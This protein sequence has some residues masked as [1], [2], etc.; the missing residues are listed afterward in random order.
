MRIPSRQFES[1]TFASPP[2]LRSFSIA[3]DARWAQVRARRAGGTLR[4]RAGA[5]PLGGRV[6]IARAEGPRFL[7]AGPRVA[8]R[9]AVVVKGA[10]LGIVGWQRGVTAGWGSEGVGQRQGR[11]RMINEPLQNPDLEV[12]RSHSQKQKLL[13][14]NVTKQNSPIHT[15]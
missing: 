10:V 15:I 6:F 3:A 2:E 7:G 11:K 9:I 1:L 5:G 4:G 14:T 13:T 12:S 8:V